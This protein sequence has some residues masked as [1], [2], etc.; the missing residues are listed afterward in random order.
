M[1][2]DDCI[3][4]AIKRNDYKLVCF[5]LKETVHNKHKTQLDFINGKS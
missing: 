5:L 4:I 1:N 3:A 2:G